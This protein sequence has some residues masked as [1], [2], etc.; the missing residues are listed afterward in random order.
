MARR[1]TLPDQLRAIADRLEAA[2]QARRA[3]LSDLMEIGAGAVEALEPLWDDAS[4]LV[5]DER[6]PGG[7]V[8]VEDP[9]PPSAPA[10]KIAS[11]QSARF[12][13]LTCP[14]CG[15]DFKRQGYEGGTDG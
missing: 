6:L 15:K 9:A 12:D 10:A 11:G 7:A 4:V 5:A 2:D 14:E 8:P 3:A 1:M 13:L